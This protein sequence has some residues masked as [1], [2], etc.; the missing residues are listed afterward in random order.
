MSFEKLVF[1][2]LALYL[3]L[4]FMI[5]PR[6]KKAWNAS[7]TVSKVAKAGLLG[8]VE[9]TR[10]TAFVASLMYLSFAL[11]TAV[12]G[13]GFGRN[14]GLLEWLVE[15][16]ARFH[17]LLESFEDVWKNWL[18]VFTLALVV[19]LYWRTQ[20]NKLKSHFE[21]VIDDEL[22]RL[23][24]Q[25]TTD[26]RGWI[27]LPPD[28]EM[29]K[30]DAEI[31][32]AEAKLKTLANRGPKD[33]A[34]RRRLR[35]VVSH[36]NEQ[37]TELDY[38]RRVAMDQLNIRQEKPNQRLSWREILLSKGLYSDLKGISKLTG[39]LTVATLSLALIG[40]AGNAGLT[41]GVW[42]RIIHLDE[43][44][45][46]ARKAD[47]EKRWKAH[48]KGVQQAALSESDQQAIR[49]LTNDFAGALS[50]NPAWQSLRTNAPGG[51]TLARELS[52]QAILEKVRVSD[53]DG[54]STEAFV[55]A[56]SRHQAEVVDEIISGRANKSRVGHI[57]AD[58]H[59]VEI[60]SWFG[61]KWG[62]VKASILE[63]AKTYHEPLQMED[64]QGALVDRVVAAAYDAG[65]PDEGSDV[66]K[67][68]RDGMKDAMKEAA[69][70]TV[71]TE[72]HRVV[73]DI[74]GGKPYAEAVNDV[75]TS[76]ISIS[77][78]RVE[79]LAVL[80]HE[81]KLPDIRDY[82]EY[83]T[84]NHG[85]WKDPY[86]PFAGGAGNGGGGFSGRGGKWR[87]WAIRVCRRRCHR[88]NASRVSLGTEANG[89]GGCGNAGH[90]R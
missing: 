13:L 73:E 14:A 58:R 74:E 65:I 60:R 6:L 1:A 20:R 71:E 68:A 10:D 32:K 89:R 3:L 83:A 35:Q 51:Q 27:T 44:R 30:L 54:N 40:V 86:H 50:K 7:R 52:R 8:A 48:P 72:L 34:E 81:R 26:S 69:R 55:D 70:E 78:G 80:F 77:R 45:V 11:I 39:R 59:G 64:L 85:N 16:A 66:M 12:L 56:F 63:H 4:N 75:R 57:V 42:Q 49:H 67:Q 29:Q 38:E 36:L 46:E 84:S 18:F 76:H 22:D 31:A 43:L 61:D 88:P 79:E 37:R 82:A 21:R 53:A 28:D 62:G 2:I 41:E 90:C 33:R 17:E 47:A 15:L 23:N 24:E 19:Y 5:L 25:R 87:K 9:F